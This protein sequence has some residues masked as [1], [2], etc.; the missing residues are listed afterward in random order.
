MTTH[1]KKIRNYLRMLEDIALVVGQCSDDDI[2]EQALFRVKGFARRIEGERL[3]LADL[4]STLHKIKEHEQFA[5]TILE[6]FPQ[7][8]QLVRGK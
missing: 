8:E 2:K 6:D 3:A 5:R 1:T 7:L 4:Q